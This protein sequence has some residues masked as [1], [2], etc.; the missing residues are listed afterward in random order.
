MSDAARYERKAMQDYAGKYDIQREISDLQTDSFKNLLVV[1]SVVSYI[2]L[3]RIAWPSGHQFPFIAW[4]SSLVLMSSVLVSILVRQWQLRLS[5]FLAIAGSYVSIVLAILTFTTETSFYLF[6]AIPIIA[7]VMYE[8][9][10]ILIWG[11]ITLAT[12]FLLYANQPVPQWNNFG[13]WVGILALLAIGLILSQ[14]SFYTALTWAFNGYQEA[15]ENQQREREKQAELKQ[16]LKSLDTAT[17]N[18]ERTNYL[19]TVARQQSEEARQL[20]Q[21]FAQNISHEL[22]TPLNLIVGFTELMIQSPEYYGPILPH[23]YLRDLT[24]VYR[25]ACH[26]QGLVN[27]VLD[28]ARIES[29]QL[30]L[31]QEPTDIGQLILD[32]A[33]TVHNLVDARGLELRTDIEPNLPIVEIDPVRIRQVLF[34]LIS[35]A[36]RF[37]D[38]GSITVGIC[39]AGHNVTCRVADTGVGIPEREINRVFE[40]F[41]QV[42][43]TTERKHEG[44]GLGLTISKHFVELHGGKIWVESAEGKGSTFFFSLPTK[45]TIEP[46]KIHVVRQTDSGNRNRERLLLAVTRSP[47]AITLLN[48]YLAQCR[49]V[50]VA[51]L[52]QAAVAIRNILPQAV[53]IDTTSYEQSLTAEDLD[54]LAQEWNLLKTPLIAGPLPGEERLRQ[55]TTAAG[56]LL[57]PVNQESLWNTLRQYEANVDKILLVDDDRDFVRLMKR[58]L[59]NPLRRYRVFSAFSG[60]EA[61]RLVQHFKPDLVLLDFRLPDIS[62][63]E[64]L[65]AL[66]R[67]PGYEKIPVIIVSAQDELDTMEAL[68]GPLIVTR[69]EGY[70]PA[71]IIHATQSVL[72]IS[73]AT[74]SRLSLQ[75]SE[76][77]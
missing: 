26:L 7:S 66:R 61:L 25:N 5:Y 72:D 73:T 21:Q 43:G 31:A 71:D 55:R 57:K 15:A 42:D 69:Q 13:V 14:Y 28:L 40:A 56:F 49:T 63:P 8:V 9:R 52:E 62:G 65:K 41:H 60:R 19:L 4:V 32:T 67:M 48:R 38:T 34:N 47:A 45:T 58:L 76:R 44:A 70:L 75:P 12:G 77:L 46:H 36:A 50:V 24:T 64:V 17:Y 6:L 20:K 30:N 68:H 33:S 74:Y 29:A 27:D 10:G 1:M 3:G 11:G 18:L 53:L 22:R 59:D 16:T 35:N 39:S 51:D 23:A 2:W 54:Q 37:T